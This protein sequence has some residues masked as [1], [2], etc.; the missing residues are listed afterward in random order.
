MLTKFSTLR[1]RRLDEWLSRDL[2]LIN[3]ATNVQAPDDDSDRRLVLRVS[4][5]GSCENDVQRNPV[6]A[7]EEERTHD[8]RVVSFEPAGSCGATSAQRA[9]DKR[10]VLTTQLSAANDRGVSSCRGKRQRRRTSASC[11]SC[12]ERPDQLDSYG[13]RERTTHLIQN[14]KSPTLRKLRVWSA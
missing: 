8:H 4:Q 6:D 12:A 3:Q 9:R 5:V 2:V 14:W 1:R 7:E 11:S 13:R 10:E